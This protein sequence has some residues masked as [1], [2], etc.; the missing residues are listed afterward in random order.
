[1]NTYLLKCLICFAHPQSVHTFAKKRQKV[2]YIIKEINPRQDFH[3]PP[4]ITR[5]DLIG[6]VEKGDVVIGRTEKD[7]DLP[8]LAEADTC[9][10]DG[11]TLPLEKL[12]EFL[13][14]CCPALSDFIAPAAPS[15]APSK[16][17]SPEAEKMRIRL[18]VCFQQKP[19]VFQYLKDERILDP[20]GHFNNN[21]EDFCHA[22]PKGLLV[23]TISTC[24]L[25]REKVPYKEICEALSIEGNSE[26]IRVKTS[27]FMKQEN[28]EKRYPKA[29]EVCQK[30][31][32]M[33]GKDFYEVL[34]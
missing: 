26:S 2:M 18:K 12:Y 31:C 20:K 1:M 32:K 9:V 33:Y 17:L 30:I 19:E 29:V 34:E 24:V 21:R 6:K 11:L 5:E 23:K 27:R 14:L 8:T 13:K 7:A 10:E 22:A 28:S 3:N 4:F 15:A 25:Q 16:A